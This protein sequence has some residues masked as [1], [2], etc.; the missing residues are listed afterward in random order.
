M[1]ISR[2]QVETVFI[3]G[4]I[5]TVDA[6]FSKA[7]ALAVR[8]QELVYVGGSAAAA[9][10]AVSPA[11]KIVDLGG[12]TVI[13]GLIESHVHFLG[14]GQRL[15]EIDI[16]WKPKAE[17]LR[18]VAEEAA[19]LGPG[20][21]IVSRG[22]NQEAWDD[23]NWPGKEDLDAVAPRNPVAL[24]RVDYHS[25]WVNTPALEAA[26]VGRGAPDPQGGEILRN[27]D[28][29]ARGILLDTAMD[30]LWAAV[31]PLGQARAMELYRLA[32]REF[33]A[34]G[35][36]S[37]GNASQNLRD[38]AVLRKTYEEGSMKLRV[39]EIM[40]MHEQAEKDFIKAGHRPFMGEYGERLSMNC[41]KVIGDGA[42]GSRSAW[43]RN[44]YAD[45]PGHKGTP[46]FTDAELYD[47]TRLAR[48][49]GYQ[50]SIH[51][52]GDAAVGQILDAYAKVLAEFPLADHRY[53]IEH[54]QMVTPEDL[55]RAA[56]LRIAP[57]MQAIHCTSDRK[58]A[59]LRL[60][61]GDIAKSYL[62]RDVIDAGLYIAGSSDAPVEPVSPFYGMHSSVTRSNAG[63]EP[64]GGWNRQWAMTREEALRSYTGWAAR[65]EFGDRRKGSLEAGKLADF[66]VL[67]RDIMTC[68]KNEII[69][70]RVLRTVIGGET[71]FEA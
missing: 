21:W 42:L 28:G 39:Y 47:F 27:P 43:L 35:I 9:K 63:F 60:T 54:F 49:H 7:S 59:L 38:H 24:M 14:E 36:T 65:A 51:G 57:V 29:E 67:D 25:V 71:V 16:Y 69:S 44:D 61:P 70:T 40:L 32:Q 13:P 8:G 19:K 53:R 55:K 41:I 62:W 20:E 48:D 3:N 22:W 26:G 52:I 4:N 2:N 58:M 5:H 23:N 37:I 56:R 45:R 18:K 1:S 68:P 33:I 10:A 6:V 17:I 11:A 31:P 46:C 30:P 34:C 64:A 15:A 12:K 50:A 66:A